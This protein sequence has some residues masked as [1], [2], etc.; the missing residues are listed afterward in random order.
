MAACRDV[1]ALTCD[2]ACPPHGVLEI[3]K[4]VSVETMLLDGGIET[5]L[6]NYKTRADGQGR[7]HGQHEP[8]VSGVTVSGPL[9][10]AGRC[11]RITYLSSTMMAPC[12]GLCDLSQRNRNQMMEGGVDGSRCKTGDEEVCVRVCVRGGSCCVRGPTLGWVGER[13]VAW[14]RARRRRAVWAQAGYR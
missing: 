10:V 2:D 13:S 12:R 4:A 6:G 11:G 1:G 8:Y 9:L 14:R 3:S 7:T 5:L